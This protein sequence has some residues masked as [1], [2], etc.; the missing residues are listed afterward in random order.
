MA[1][2]TPSEP[3][4]FQMFFTASLRRPGT[5]L[6][7]LEIERLRQAVR[8]TRAESP[9]QINAWVVMPDHI[10]TIWTLPDA[11]Y[12]A[13]WRLIKRRF[14][15]GLPNARGLWQPRLWAQPL[16]NQPDYDRHMRACWMDPVRHGLVE[17]AGDWPYSSF[18]TRPALAL[19]G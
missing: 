8:V 1:Q 4:H 13:R 12:V 9:F 19:A 2:H 15:A 6:L 10:H 18:H 14:S 11:D 17:A 7:I 3:P 16:V 5:D